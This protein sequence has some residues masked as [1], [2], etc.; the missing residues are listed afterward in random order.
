MGNRGYK[1]KRESLGYSEKEYK[2][3][4]KRVREMEEK[5]NRLWEEKNK[6]KKN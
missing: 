3:M 6:K 4:R 2:E 5:A 1:Y